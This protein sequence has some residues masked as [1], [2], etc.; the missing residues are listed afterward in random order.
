MIGPTLS[1]PAEHV[2]YSAMS[3]TRVEGKLLTVT[4]PVSYE[5]LA[6]TLTSPCVPVLLM[7][8]DLSSYCN[9]AGGTV[10]LCT[11]HTTTPLKV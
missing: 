10:L 3:A 6:A 7:Y 11:S 2:A 5:L 1:K 8:I 4:Q 9:V